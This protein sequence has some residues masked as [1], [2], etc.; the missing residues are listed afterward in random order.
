[1]ETFRTIII[2]TFPW[3]PASVILLAIPLAYVTRGWPQKTGK[4]RLWLYPVTWTLALFLLMGKFPEVL[5]KNSTLLEIL[6][7]IIWFLFFIVW[8]VFPLVIAALLYTLA[9]VWFFH[10]GHPSKLTKYL[11]LALFCP[12][13]F[14]MVFYGLISSDIAGGLIPKILEY[15]FYASIYLPTIIAMF[16]TKEVK[17]K[18]DG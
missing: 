3:L 12:F 18:A 8:T 5:S 15:C 2:A 7:Q 6:W 4:L 10:K 9:K 14:L 11:V 13:I 1:M 16:I 17:S